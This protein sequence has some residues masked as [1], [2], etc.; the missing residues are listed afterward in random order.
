MK[1]LLSAP[2]AVQIIALTACLVLLGIAAIGVSTYVS[3]EEDVMETAEIQTNSAARA[4]AVLY[5]L[6]VGGATLNIDNGNLVSVDR[7]S[8]GTLRDTD[9]VDRTAL[10]IGG[11]STVFQKQGEDFVRMSTNVKKENGERAIGTKLA[12]DSQAYAKISK[13]EVYIGKATLFGSEYMTGYIPVKSKSGAPV[14]ILFVGIPMQVFFD[15]LA[16][17]QTMIL[18]S[19][20]LVMGAVGLLGYFV[21]RRA[22]RPL[23][24]LTGAV[25]SLSSGNLDTV[26]P[27][28]D[29]SNEFGNIAKALEVFRTNAHE[30]LV[31][32]GRSEADRIA[33][34][35]E[36]ARNDDEKRT[37]DQQIEFAVTELASGLARL[38]QGD[39]TRTLDKPFSGRLDQLRMDFNT[40]LAHLKN[41]LQQIRE[42]TLTIQHNGD[43]MLQ[44]SND[45]SRRTESQAASLEQTAAAVEEITITVKSSAE[46]AREANQAV[47]RTRQSADSS[48]TVVSN[49]VAAMGRIEDASK[50]IEQIIEVIDDIAFQT[51]LLALNAGIEAARAGE[52]GK[53]FA[54]VAQEVREL[55]QRSADAAREIKGLINQSSNEVE[56]GALL[57]QQAG[58]V[59]SEISGQIVDVSKHVE[60]IATAAQ[61]QS[62]ALH[63]VNSSVN[64]MDQMTQQ[65]AAM[66][67]ESSAASQMLANEVQEL[68]AL[69]QQFRIEQASQ[70]YGREQFARVA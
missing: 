67:E 69:V 53:G 55:A 13:G 29:R 68:L 37:L 2:V 34:D 70:S 35:E 36:R 19:S 26:I 25:N 17:L 23:G 5:E 7:A 45:L 30:K 49:A 58:E 64:Q 6:K 32:E 46:R 57:V 15:H 59:L 20:A 65:N 60:T 33:A 48:G 18:F 12:T 62:S 28:A 44:S 3:L 51:N 56:T 42:R 40:S 27:Y 52:A 22:L 1:K 39:L 11:V 9:L 43:E 61:D 31:I 47:N 41:V 54:V 24:V 50:K 38:S 8:I 16:G 4:M 66:A 63:E 14:G 21:I 10:I